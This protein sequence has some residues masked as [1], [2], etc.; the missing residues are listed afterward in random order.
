MVHSTVQT[1]S[2][3][4]EHVRERIVR[5]KEVVQLL[6]ISRS[7]I[8]DKLNPSSKRHDPSFPKPVKLGGA[9]IGWRLSMILAWIE[10]LNTTN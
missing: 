3:K 9:A 10:S 8:Y 5:V 2:N 1:F 4:V 7:T 6:G